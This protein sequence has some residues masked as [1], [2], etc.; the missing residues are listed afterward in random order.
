MR[1]HDFLMPVVY[2]FLSFV[3]LALLT[4]SL[5]FSTNISGYLQESIYKTAAQESNLGAESLHYILDGYDILSGWISKERQVSPRSYRSNA[6][7]AF[8]ALKEYDL[9]IFRFSD[10]I[11]YYGRNDKMLSVR[12]TSQT[13]LLFPE[14]EDYDAFYDYLDS[15]SGKQVFCTMNFGVEPDKNIVVVAYSLT[16]HAL[17][18]FTLEYADVYKLVTTDI[19]EDTSLRFITDHSGKLLWSNAAFLES[20]LLKTTETT[21]QEHKVTIDG[22]NYLCSSASVVNGMTLY[23]LTPVTT[24]FDAFMHA[25]Y[26]LVAIC[27]SL[28][29]VGVALLFWGTKRSSEPIVE[30]LAALHNALPNQSDPPESITDSLKQVCAQYS[31]MVHEH[32]HQQAM[33]SNE[34]LCDL[35]VLRIISG[36]Y[37]D[38][39]ELTNLCNWLNLD[40][41][42]RYY[43]ICLL[44]FDEPPGKETRNYTKTYLRRFSDENCKAC[45]CLTPDGNS[46][47][48]LVNLSNR[49][50]LLRFTKKLLE[51]LQAKQSVSIGVG[52]I[53]ESIDV[54]GYSYLEA[55]TALEQRLIYGKNICILYDD[56]PN[57]N[58]NAMIIYP[59]KL[60][61]GYVKCLQRW[62]PAEIEEKLNQIIEF[63]HENNLPIQQVKCICF[64]LTA[65]LMREITHM[66]SLTASLDRSMFDVFSIAEYTSVVELAEKILQLSNVVQQYLEK[67]KNCRKNDLIVQCTELMQ[68]N[69]DNSQFSLSTIAEL[70]NVTPQTLRRNFKEATGHTLSSYLINLRMERARCLLAETELDINSICL[71]CGY[72]DLS[73]FSRL[74]KNETGMSPG[75]YRKMIRQEHH[76]DDGMPDE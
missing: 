37:S 11:L 23:T 75:A 57:E 58:S 36:Q 39:E 16:N 13:E 53:Y 5:W 19:S 54:L 76:L 65:A 41:P 63:I 70:F 12:G 59:E 73:S 64:E 38:Q 10:L 62:E 45:F 15:I 44:L 2:A 49:E 21:E 33:L 20:A 26:M 28:L 55:H 31:Y 30:M 34:E 60:L 6:Y 14:L 7:L 29:L 72:I 35:F 27:L 43:A 69:I 4:I 40:F 52:S 56:L 50:T 74:F 8:S 1:Q 68:Q 67:R 3:I 51:D 66:G 18:L 42:Y 24:Q 9:P 48:G 47:V 17:A 22:N 32:R 46:A 25:V 71:K 61:D